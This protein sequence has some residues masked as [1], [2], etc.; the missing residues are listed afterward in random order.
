MADIPDAAAFYASRRIGNRDA[1][2]ENRVK[3]LSV[4]EEY[5]RSGKDSMIGGYSSFCFLQEQVNGD[6]VVAATT[7]VLDELLHHE[8]AYRTPTDTLH[9]HTH[10]HAYPSAPEKGGV[11]YDAARVARF[12]EISH[13]LITATPCFPVQF[14]GI[15]CTQDAV[16]VCGYGDPAL[17]ELRQRFYEAM[18]RYPD[19]FI[20]P[21][22]QTVDNIRE[23]YGKGIAAVTAARLLT[24][25]QNSFQYVATTDCHA[26]TDLGTL[27]VTHLTFTANNGWIDIRNHS[28]DR[29]RYQAVRIPLR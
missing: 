1:L 25:L 20:L 6:A 19:A 5:V 7:T 2:R 3:V 29:E 15:A 16:L 12:L 18:E 14:K 8:T 10:V 24:S 17:D 13:E 21:A 23:K 4:I 28:G 22:G 27:T 9:F 26:E 11:L